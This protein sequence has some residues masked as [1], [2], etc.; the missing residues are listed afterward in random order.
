MQAKVSEPEAAGAATEAEDKWLSPGRFALILT[1]LLFIS[2]P[3]VVLG[4]ET[5]VFRDFGLFGYPLAF[6]QRECFWH[7]ELPFWNPYNNCGVPFLAQWNTMSF[8]IPALL[9]LVLPLGWSLGFFCLLH[10]FFGGMGMYALAYRWTNS[11]LAASLS[12]LVFAYNGLALNSLM[13]PSQ[14]ATY[15]WMPWV[16]MAVELGWQQG[17][18]K[19]LWAALAG[20]LQMLAGG[21]ETI[22]FT[23]VLIAGLWIISPQPTPLLSRALSPGAKVQKSPSNLGSKWPR[24]PRLRTGVRFGMIILIV[25]GLSAAQLLPFLDLV[26]H[27]QRGH[28]FLDLRWALP[29]R[30]W[31]NFLVPMAFGSPGQSGVWYEHEQFWTSSF[32]LG[33]GPVLLGLMAIW[34]QHNRRVWFLAAAALGGYLLALGDQTVIYGWVRKLFPPLNGMTFPVKFVIIIAFVWPLLAGVAVAHLSK[35]QPKP[36]RAGD[37]QRWDGERLVVSMTAALM[38][39]IVLILLWARV[40]PLPLD[41]FAATL[42]NGVSRAIFLA[43]A[44]LLLVLLGRTTSARPRQVLSLSLLALVWFDVR[45]HEPQQNP[46]GPAAIYDPGLVRTE[47]AMNPQPALG[48]ARVMVSPWANELFEQQHPRIKE[49][50]DGYLAARLGYYCDCNLLDE[51]PKVNGFFALYPYASD[52]ISQLL[53]LSTN[54]NFPRLEDFV[55]VSHVTAPGECTVWERRGTYLSAINAGQEPVFVDDTNALRRLIRSDFD[56]TKTVFLPLPEKG[57]LSTTNQTDA[58]VLWYHFGR[59]EVVAEVEA[60]APSMVTISQ[61]YYHCW[62]AYIDNA[63]VPLLRANFAFQALE[64]PAGKHHIRLAYEERGFRVGGIISILTALGCVLGTPASR[65]LLGRKWGSRQFGRLAS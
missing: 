34:K 14:T 57:L 39:L 12:G 52:Q 21:P 54:S 28:H 16:M 48:E 41:N 47:L 23:W 61:T 38:A 51:V 11:R 33:T 43:L 58:R 5:F 35:F 8:Y 13:W 56:G 4:L 53:Y 9:Y 25:F 65:Q 42:R 62:R 63:R 36:T 24:V 19:V 55:C 32:Y 60:S 45:T 46:T 64:V 50:K 29:S 10:L 1:V 7:G 31:A 3:Q 30:G 27:C 44:C 26:W 2:F 40:S 6:F 20:T 22:L 17:G 49:V 37:A 15:A 18:M 59:E